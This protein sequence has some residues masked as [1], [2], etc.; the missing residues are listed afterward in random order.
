M[1]KIVNKW[2]PFI[3]LIAGINCTSQ[4]S[5]LNEAEFRDKIYAC[6]LG[7]NIGG[8]LGM[9][10]E[11]KQDI[12]NL[13]FYTNLKPNEPAANDDLDLQILWLKALEENNG[14][15]NAYTLGKYWLKYIPV[16]WN[17]YGVA[18][19]N[20]K[21]GIVP[22]LSGEFNNDKWK[23]SN[24]AWIR[25]EIWACIAPGNPL[26][27]A[28]LAWE[29]AC[30]DHG[31]AEGTIAEIFT[32]SLESA[33]FIEHDRDKL[34]AFAL[35]MIPENSKTAIAVRNVVESKKEGKDWQRARLDVIKV[36]EDLGWF[37]APRNVAFTMIG[38]LWGDGDFGKSICIAVN[39]GD[40]TDCTGATLG[41]ILGIIGGTKAIPAKWRDP[42]GEKIINVAISGFDAPKDLTTFTDKTLAMA[43]KMTEIYKM[44]ISITGEKTRISNATGLLQIDKNQLNEL[45]DR[46]PYLVICNEQETEV[47]LDYLKEPFFQDNSIR[48]LKISVKNSGTRSKSF[49]VTIKGIPEGMVIKGLTSSPFPLS[50]GSSLELN[51]TIEIQVALPV[52]KLTISV[53]SVDKMIEIPFVLIKI[54]DKNL[55]L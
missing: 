32:A 22:P 30:V 1:K 33:A 23:T 26:F 19:E 53:T 21:M 4:K 49:E 6:W 28:Q 47:K 15:I 37:Q 42:I 54:K 38:W 17:E 16:N 25:S 24:G 7:K 18:I 31:T 20:M 45:F 46:S 9:P 48:P 5:N 51:L 40:D 39:C 2:L 8:T 10:F 55:L 35:S 52:T 13:S 34:I 50:P 3:L 41:S 44:P 43:K 29:D 14:R 27:A 12:N 11:G 36:T